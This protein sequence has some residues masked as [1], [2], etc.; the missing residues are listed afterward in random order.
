MNNTTLNSFFVSMICVQ[1]LSGQH[2]LLFDFIII[3]SSVLYLMITHGIVALC[4]IPILDLFTN[5]RV[6][7]NFFEY[8]IYILTGVAF[9]ITMI[10]EYLRFF[11]YLNP[12]TW[13]LSVIR[14]ISDGYF[15]S[16][17][18]NYAIICI[19]MNLILLAIA[20]LLF[21]WLGKRIKIKAEYGI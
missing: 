17:T 2:L 13:A 9:P 1:I 18:L 6:A 21:S 15:T 10:P 8:P 19:C 14:N 3:L 16:E 20:K 11:C 12:I 7:V 5:I 4:I